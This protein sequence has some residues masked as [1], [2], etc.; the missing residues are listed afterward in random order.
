MRLPAISGDANRICAVTLEE[1]AATR[2]ERGKGV[3]QDGEE[4]GGKERRNSAQRRGQ[5]RPRGFWLVSCGSF[6]EQHE[7]GSHVRGM[8]R[9]PA[10]FAAR[11]FPNLVLVR[12]IS[13]VYDPACSS[14]FLSAV[15]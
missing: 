5:R 12:T 13:A 4:D 11:I 6:E 1:F 2:L 9:C 14:Y 3:A 7:A 8:A 15:I 10:G